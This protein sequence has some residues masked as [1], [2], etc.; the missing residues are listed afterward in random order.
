MSWP[1][2][3]PLGCKDRSLLFVSMIILALIPLSIIYVCDGFPVVPRNRSLQANTS[4]QWPIAYSDHSPLAN[5]SHSG[6]NPQIGRRS[7]QHPDRSAGRKKRSVQPRDII[8]LNIAPNTPFTVTVPWTSI[9]L[10][11]E[12]PVARTNRLY[13]HDSTHFASKKWYLTLGERYSDWS[14]KNLVAETD[15]NWSAYTIGPAAFW[16]SK[17]RMFKAG[18]STSGP[19]TF[20]IAPLTNL[21]CTRFL[22]APLTDTNYRW[23]LQI[24]VSSPE[25]KETPALVLTDSTG[26]DTPLKNIKIDSKGP[27]ADDLINIV[28]GIFG[29]TNNWLLLAEQA[30]KASNQDCVV[31]M[32]A[33]PTL[34]VVPPP[35]PP[36]GVSH[37][38]DDSSR[39]D[40]CSNLETIFP[41]KA[42]GD[43]GGTPFFSNIVAPNNFSCIQLTGVGGDFLGN[44]T[45]T[46]CIGTTVFPSFRPKKR[47]NLWWWCGT[48]KLYDGF[49]DN[50]SGT[51]ALITL[52]LPV[53]VT[54]VLPSKYPYRDV[55]N[56]L[57]R[58][59]SL[60]TFHNPTYIDAI[61]VP[62]GVPDEYKLADQ[63]AAGFESIFLWI[64][65]NKNVD[66]IN[67]IH[68][69]VQLL[70]NYTRV[71][72][73]AVHQQ[74]SKTSLMA[75]Q[76]RIAV[77]ML[78]AE[79]GGVCAIF[80]Q[81]CCVFIPNNTAA[82]GSLTKA[83]DGLR[84]LTDTMKSHSGV[85]TTLWESWMDVFGKYKQL[86]ASVLVS[87][88][89][90][91]AILVTCGCCCI[92]CLRQLIQ[93]LITVAISPPPTDPVL[94][95]PILL[96]PDDYATS[97]DSGTE[98]DDDIV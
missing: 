54:P 57:R 2:A 67:Y 10:S 35:I 77:D 65:P 84:T 27:T 44:V 33:R 70:G 36:S 16:R 24:C 68:F 41:P 79:K 71:A 73:E 42:T 14:W 31:C 50:S 80:G 19:L 5:T 61:G 40:D 17:I 7:P 6:S 20:A 29:N 85:D 28:T 63:V 95:M 3:G 52:I 11:P 87:V 74:L 76:N 75:F 13:Y 62:R 94:T 90:F 53:S 9:P 26:N 22:L 51:C 98:D 93:R 38:M 97:S 88:S 89:V 1:F 37:L 72:L 12:F 58:K 23:K 45:S 25:K 78:L 92:P 83:I 43:D 55:D 32:T 46:W 56:G 81:S 30:A 64:T 34:R 8:T 4:Y 66:R 15:A 21:G 39:T 91:T 69:N 18:G 60:P 86:V 59:R 47:V 96:V 49:P 48:H 82:D